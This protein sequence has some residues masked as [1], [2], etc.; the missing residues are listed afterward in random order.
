MRGMKIL[1]IPSWYPTED[2]PL[3]GCFFKEQAIALSSMGHEVVVL[4]ASFQNRRHIK[5]SINYRVR[6]LEYNGITEYAYQVPAWGV[7]RVPGICSRIFWN[8]IRKLWK[9]TENKDFDLIHVQSFYPAGIAAYNLHKLTNIP[10]VYTEHSSGLLLKNL[11]N[12]QV[13][14][15]RKLFFGSNQIIA[16][17]RNLKKG[18][19]SYGCPKDMIRVIPNMVDTSLF[20]CDVRD[21]NDIYTYLVVAKLDTNKRVDWVIRAFSEL[22]KSTD[23]IMLRIIGDGEQKQQLIDLIHELNLDGSV[24]L[25]GSCSRAKVAQVMQQA[26]SFVLDSEVETF[27]VVYIEAMAC[28]LPI[29]IP[30]W[31]SSNI[32]ILK[33]NYVLVEEDSLEALVDA[34]RKIYEQRDCF[35]SSL[36]S[37][38]CVKYYSG[39]KIAKRITNVYND[40]LKKRWEKNSGK[41]NR[42]YVY[43]FKISLRLFPS[44]M[45]SRIFNNFKNMLAKRALRNVDGTV[46][47][48]RKIRM[49]MDVSIGCN[50]GLGDNAFIGGPVDMGN[51]VMMGPNVVIYRSNHKAE[52][53]DI[54]MANQGMTEE[55]KLEIGNDVWIGDGSIILPGCKRIGNGCIIG[56]RSVITKDV[57]NYAVVVGNPGRIVRIRCNTDEKR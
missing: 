33:D 47:F 19:I 10:L 38:K 41:I 51:D 46:N 49:S 7:W 31:N 39:E 57:P 37:D 21:R 13:N 28:G 32:D 52:R 20:K 35:D 43:L 22:K 23:F 56:A 55:A 30:K 45:N 11:K 8:N 12:G 40:A 48:G 34:M 54:P 25:E 42:W 3:S 29:V 14:Q 36:I 53:I 18:L 50:S 17:S 24:L 1:F 16:V 4:N 2:D 27:G 5:S 9:Y 26:D 6:K 15:L 44:Y